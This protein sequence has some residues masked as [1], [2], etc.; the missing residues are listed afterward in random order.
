M[1]YK[2]IEKP[3]FQKVLAGLSDTALG[4]ESVR[5]ALVDLVNS[6]AADLAPNTLAVGRQEWLVAVEAEKAA[7][8]R[9][10]ESDHSNQHIA[11]KEPA[12]AN[13][14]RGDILIIGA[15]AAGISAAKEIR[16]VNR[17]ARVT[18]LGEEK[19]LPYYRPLLTKLVADETIEQ[20]TRL[21]LK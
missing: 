19:H 20:S 5:T 14:F 6:D 15:S 13:T 3:H 21:S 7:R 16:R 17:T 8:E 10:Q 12:M 18:L 1:E 9:A 4:S 2:T 11:A